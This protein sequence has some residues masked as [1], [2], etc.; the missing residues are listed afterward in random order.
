M[1]MSM[2]VMKPLLVLLKTTE[3]YLSAV[4]RIFAHRQKFNLKI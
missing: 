3:I 2:A 1:W 4:K